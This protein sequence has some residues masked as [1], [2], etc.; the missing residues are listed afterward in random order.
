MLQPILNIGMQ[1]RLT[2]MMFFKQLDCCCLVWI[3]QFDNWGK[4][5]NLVTMINYYC[6]T[7][8]IWKYRV[9]MKVCVFIYCL[10]FFIKNNWTLMQHT[11]FFFS[12]VLYTAYFMVIMI[13]FLT[14]ISLLLPVVA[15][16]YI[17]IYMWLDIAQ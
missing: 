3:V 7:I 5:G 1:H 6:K 11:E 8:H 13:R 17:L 2:R 9:S 10:S 14:C 15:L 4:F 16:M 12:N